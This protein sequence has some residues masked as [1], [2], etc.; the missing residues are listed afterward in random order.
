M[1]TKSQRVERLKREKNPWL[2]L[3]EIRN[4]ARQGHSSIPPEWL[5]TYFRPW[6]VYT[7][8]DGQ[9]V[10]G[11]K[12][13]E[14]LSVPYFMLRIRIP[15]G[16]LTSQ[17]V[18]T[19]ADLSAIHGNGVADITVRQNIQLH[20]V[21]IESL[22]EIFEQLESVG[23]STTGACGD[24]TRNITGCPLAGLDSRELA[25][26]SPFVQALDRE[27]AGNPDFYNLPRKFKITV[28]A[29]PDWC[30]YPEINDI[31]LTATLR[32]LRSAGFQPAQPT[33]AQAFRPE[34]FPGHS[35]PSSNDRNP[36]QLDPSFSSAPSSNNRHSE[37]SPRSE[38]SLFSLPLATRH[39]PLATSSPNCHSDRSDP[40]F[41]S[42]PSFG[43][44]G[45]GAE[46]SLPDLT[47]TSSPNLPDRWSP[48]AGHPSSLPLATR[49]SPLATSSSETGFSLRVAGGLSTEPHLSVRLNAFIHPHQ[50]IPVVRAITELFRESA[51]LRQSR[52][53]ARL[54]YLFLEHGWT[55][56]SF[57]SAIEQRSATNSIPP[58]PNS[59]LPTSIAIISA[60]NP[61]SSPASIPSAPRSFVAASLH[62]NSA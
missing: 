4:F 44:P 32:P 46:E 25:D 16:L 28:S 1:E 22:P 45:R 9:G 27:L 43:A 12:G 49:H 3:D 57:L 51:V 8:G 61:K 20:W 24:V 34:A 5:G 58:S 40:A 26:V 11:G 50:V 54:K 47:T 2:H 29:C 55:P 13:G 6:G 36:N 21:R 33:V 18:R 62:N 38:E 60:C 15:N 39:S 10:T 23:L 19:I 59:F 48:V 30:S 37:R 41:S 7:Q 42:A 31:A 52:E 56:A 17:Q 35:M 14:G 53:R